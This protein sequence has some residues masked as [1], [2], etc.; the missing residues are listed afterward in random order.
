[1]LLEW[2]KKD[3]VNLAKDMEATKLQCPSSKFRLRGHFGHNSGPE[4]SGKRILVH[5]PDG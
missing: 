1:M 4:V 2:K 5:Y 3:I